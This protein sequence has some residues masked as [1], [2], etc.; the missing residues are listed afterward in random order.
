MTL[1][2]YRGESRLLRLEPATTLEGIAQTLRPEPLETL[3]EIKAFYRPEIHRLR[4]LDRIGQM[5]L[6]LQDAVAGGL[7]FKA[8]LMGHPG[9]GKTT[10]MGKMLLDLEAQFRPLRLSVTSEL[11]PGTLRFYDVLLLILI[12]LVQEASHPAVIGFSNQDLDA[13]IERVR[14]HLSTRWTKHLRVD[15]K[16][17]TA[18]LGPSLLIRLLGN[19]KLGDTREQGATE[20]EI[21]FVSELVELMNDVCFECNHLLAK[22][23]QGRQWLIVL[24]DFEKIGLAP[25]TIRDV[26][27][28]LRPHFQ[29]L[30]ANLVV[31]IPV[32]L[33]YSEDAQVI[34]PP[35]FQTFLLP[36]I[37][38]YR[39][40]H[41]VDSAVVEALSNVVTARAGESLFEP[42]ALRRCCL[43]SGGNIRDLF[44]LVRDAML[45][46][47]LRGAATIS[48]A[49]ANSAIG[50]LRHEYKQ[51]LGSTSS[52]EEKAV[53]LEDKLKRLVGIYNRTDPA[54]E[55]PNPVLYLLL[56]QRCVLQYNG[57]GWMG[58]HPLVV[59]LLIE[60]GKLAAGTPGGSEI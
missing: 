49:D 5:R 4:G 34:L 48:G 15:Q 28:G 14:N 30:A 38:V 37:A 54:A 39:Q 50:S 60:F 1:G 47:R 52:L 17:F 9:V 44:T 46:A 24:E 8:F 3:A 27:I 11:N 56:R 42:Q 18:G 55:V 21:S 19:I 13:L 25:S 57:T 23:Q 43:A 22:H 10:E 32:W 59:D 6:C 40:D 36:D 33:Q 29:S 41:S 12:R 51:R 16:E 35:N 26:F 20:Y 58:V 2:P 53:S 7:P 45:S 31:T